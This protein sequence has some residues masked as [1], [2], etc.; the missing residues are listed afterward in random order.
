MFS[1]YLVFLIII[2]YNNVYFNQLN[3]KIIKLE[4][5]NDNLIYKLNN[6]NIIIN[7]LKYKLD[8]TKSINNMLKVHNKYNIE[9]KNK[10]IDIIKFIK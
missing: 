6:K 10:D 7:E 9:D 8:Q 4:K 2:I 5:I 1:G 3:N